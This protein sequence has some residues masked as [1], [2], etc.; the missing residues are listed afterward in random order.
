MF[1]MRVK[2]QRHSPS[3]DFKTWPPAFNIRQVVSCKQWWTDMKY[4]LWSPSERKVLVIFDFDIYKCLNTL[5]SILIHCFF[6]YI[7]KSFHKWN[8]N[9]M[10]YIKKKQNTILTKYTK[11]I[12]R[13][14]PGCSPTVHTTS[15]PKNVSALQYWSPEVKNDNGTHTR[16][17]ARQ[18]PGCMAGEWTIY[19]GEEEL[20]AP[21][22]I[23][24]SERVGGCGVG[25]GL[26]ED[27]LLNYSSTASVKQPWIKKAS[28]R[29]TLGSGPALN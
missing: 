21:R 27:Y 22:P 28:V 25:L 2:P 10:I 20:C 17:K 11:Q 9:M 18:R 1:G 12:N 16:H 4:R 8:M 6:F 7:L 15:E 24:L 23:C 29:Q 13:L 19:L 3:Y 26:I 14:K 5:K